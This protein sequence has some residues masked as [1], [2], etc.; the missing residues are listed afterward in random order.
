MS[1]WL[2]RQWHRIGPWHVLL[3]PLS[4]LFR[5]VVA[6]RRVAYRLG[7]FAGW[8]APVPVIVIGNITVGG[9]GKTPLTLWLAQYLKQHGYHPGIVSRG[10]GVSARG[11]VREVTLASS[12]AEVGDEPLLLARRADCPV[13][14]GKRRPAAAAA[15]LVAH[16]E[17][18]VLICDDGL[19]HYALGRDVEIALV[20]RG[21]FGN[22][23]LL[24]AGPLREPVNRLAETD[25]VVA[26]SGAEI[27]GAHVMRLS[28]ANFR[29]VRNPQLSISAAD[30]SGQR[31]HAVAGIAHPQRFFDSLATLGLSF[32]PHAFPDHHPYRPEDLQFADAQAVVM[33]EK[34][35]VKCLSFAQP[36]W[37]YLEVDAGV[38]AALGE[39][40]LQLIRS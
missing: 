21:G 18:D 23:M 40:I 2:E 22:C 26:S 20:G 33:T 14:V 25:I 16:P 4:L 7:I 37:W 10:Y 15:L 38:D 32:A 19:Q 5:G 17:C 6:L 1:F 35:A 9:T 24:P 27:P 29:N 36:H 13:W 39:R 8:R 3:W 28:G 30:F 34:D 31:L 11:M 12:A